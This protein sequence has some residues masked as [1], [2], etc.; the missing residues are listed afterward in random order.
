[1]MNMHLA[2]SMSGPTQSFSSRLCAEITWQCEDDEQ[3]KHSFYLYRTGMANSPI[4]CIGKTIIFVYCVYFAILL[5]FLL[6]SHH[7]KSAQI[8]GGVY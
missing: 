1:M 5:I 2:K 7:P 8:Q 4:N 6:W 3:D